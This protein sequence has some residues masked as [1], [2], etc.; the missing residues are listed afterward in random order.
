MGKKRKLFFVNVFFFLVTMQVFSQDLAVPAN[1]VASRTDGVNIFY[2][3]SLHEAVD[4]ASSLLATPHSPV[5]I[6]I[7]LLSDIEIHA[8]IIIGDNINIT[9]VPYGDRIIMRGG[10][11]LDGPLFWINGDA[12]SLALGNGS[13]SLV[14]DGGFLNTPSIEAHAPLVSVNGHDSKFIMYDGVTLQNNYNKSSTAASNSYQNGSGVFINVFDPPFNRPAEFIMK[15]G[16]IQGNFNKVQN[17]FSLG[18]GVF[19]AHFGIFTMEGGS[20]INNTARRAGGGVF[21]SGDSSFS[22]TGGVI[23]GNTAIEG[24]STPKMYGHSIF[25]G[26]TDGFVRLYRNDALHENEILTYTGSPSGDG[27][28]G[29]GEKW[30][31]PQTIFRRNLFIT[32]TVLLLVMSFGSIVFIYKK[33]SSLAEKPRTKTQALIEAEALLTEREK[34]V[35]R[36]LMSDK[37][38]RQISEDLG[39]SVSNVNNH[40]EK[41]YRKLNVNSYTELLVK[42]RG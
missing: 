42:L 33:R 21:I 1:V 10:D 40:S 14:V 37:T 3:T 27:V 41:I 8:S 26:F 31:T 4:T 24:Y 34:D 20:I 38:A 2:Y 25:V 12:A 9:I 23:Y 39:C 7:T 29:K 18:G 28:F 30:H 11:F 32:V 5:P 35:L 13:G 15:G 19:A 6:E 17:P 22:K 16:T 36:L